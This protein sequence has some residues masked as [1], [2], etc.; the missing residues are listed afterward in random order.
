MSILISE[1][2]SNMAKYEALSFRISVTS[3]N[4]LKL[5]LFSIV[6]DLEFANYKQ[7]T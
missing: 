5:L 7:T 3:L 6:Y 2:C 1:S 4:I